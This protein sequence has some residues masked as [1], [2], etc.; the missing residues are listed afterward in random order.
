MGLSLRQIIAYAVASI[1]Q[2]GLWI[3]RE[4]RIKA[5][6]EDPAGLIL[7][8]NGILKTLLRLVR[9]LIKREGNKLRWLKLECHWL[10]YANLRRSG[11]LAL[12]CVATA[13]G[14]SNTENAELTRCYQYSG[15]I[16]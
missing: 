13:L 11:T 7:Q 5:F 6:I 2:A 1:Y 3:L 10:G 8:A 12:T 9:S 14:S 16:F 15:N 4:N